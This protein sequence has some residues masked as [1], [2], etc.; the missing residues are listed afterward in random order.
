MSFLKML[1]HKSRRKAKVLSLAPRLFVL[2]ER[3]GEGWRASFL[4]CGIFGN[5]LI[6][7]PKNLSLFKPL[8]TAKGGVKAVLQVEESADYKESAEEI[9]S[10]AGA[11]LIT[12]DS[13]P[14]WQIPSSRHHAIYHHDFQIR[15]LGRDEDGHNKWFIKTQD[16]ILLVGQPDLREEHNP[17]LE[18]YLLHRKIDADELNAVIG[19]PDNLDALTH[20]GVGLSE[21]FNAQRVIH[22]F[23][24]DL[25]FIAV[26]DD[27]EFERNDFEVI[28]PTARKQLVKLLQNYGAST[29]G[30]QVFTRG[31]HEIA[32]AKPNKALA[33]HP[34]DSINQKR[35][36]INIV[37][38]TQ[39]WLAL[40]ES[41]LS[42][43]RK[44]EIAERFAEVMPFNWRK[45]KA[46]SQIQ[47]TDS[48]FI[49]RLRLKQ[50]VC[51]EHYKERRPRGVLGAMFNASA[52]NS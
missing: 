25:P 21:F 6:G 38:P 33:S 45:V 48:Q 19:S 35:S 3:E 30:G 32:L 49:N 46:P 51:T 31:P 22:F 34:L 47:W 10:F 40:L 8:L 12:G 26:F 50:K 44:S 43:E 4:W 15:W 17:E 41:D 7:I 11:Y 23:E 9:F 16:S 2:G 27:I 18:V 28:G 5:Y 20:F 52:R 24:K 39:Y 14:G 1:S 37:T 13:V 42:A 29:K 36:R